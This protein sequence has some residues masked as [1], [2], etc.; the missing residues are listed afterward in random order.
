MNPEIINLLLALVPLALLVV[1][2]SLGRFPGEKAIERLRSLVTTSR[3]AGPVRP[4]PAST[5][6]WLLPVCGGR[7]VAGSLAGRGPPLRD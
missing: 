6:G 3:R 5:L 2:L 1:M 7:L 4:S